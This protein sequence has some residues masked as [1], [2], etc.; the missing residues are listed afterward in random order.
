MSSFKIHSTIGSR[1]FIQVLLHGLSESSFM[2]SNHQL[3][4]QGVHAKDIP[5]VPLNPRSQELVSNHH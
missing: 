1:K 5:L 2:V 3:M 4:V